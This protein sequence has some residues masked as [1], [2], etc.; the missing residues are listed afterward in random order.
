MLGSDVGLSDL[1]VPAGHFDVGVSEDFHECELIASA[2][3]EL[4]GER[5]AAGMRA[6]AH[7]GDAGGLSELA[8]DL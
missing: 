4:Y 1:D 7:C 3:Q 2:S 5:M 8:Q 6:H